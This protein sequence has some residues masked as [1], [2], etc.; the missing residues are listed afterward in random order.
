MPSIILMGLRGVPGIPKRLNEKIKGLFDFY[1]GII[2]NG[3]KVP[4]IL[5]ANPAASFEY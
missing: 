1:P 5:V 3:S 4:I 2:K